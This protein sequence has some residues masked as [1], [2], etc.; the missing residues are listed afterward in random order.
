MDNAL[1]VT[2]LGNPGPEY[3]LT[4]HNIGFIVADEL[5]A[6]S[7]EFSWQNKFL[8]QYCKIRLDDR[9]IILLKPETYMN[10]SGKS[11][12]MAANFFNLDIDQIIIIHDDLDLPFGTIKAKKGGGT[13]GHKGIVSCKMLLGSSDFA[14]IRVGIGRP[15]Y[16]GVTDFVLARFSKD[17]QI[18][19]DSI[20]KTAADAVQ[21]AASFGLTKTM[22]K[23][24]TKETTNES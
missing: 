14:R 16:G 7:G 20:V 17:E 5:F 1:L 18:E 19:L 6:R 13:G 23:F 21:Y 2:G 10:L 9:Q 22:N 12:A 24:N 11:V 4:R 15:A 8:G 3:D